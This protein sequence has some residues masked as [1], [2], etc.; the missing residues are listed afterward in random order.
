M[1]RDDMST[2]DGERKSGGGTKSLWAVTRCRDSKETPVLLPFIC[3]A[4]CTT[5]GF[6]SNALT[7]AVAGLT[8]ED[9]N[10]LNFVTAVVLVLFARVCPTQDAAG[11]CCCAPSERRSS[12]FLGVFGGS[13]PS[14]SPFAAH[15]DSF[16]PL[17]AFTDVLLQAYCWSLF[18]IISLSGPPPWATVGGGGGGGGDKELLLF[19]SWSAAAMYGE[20]VDDVT[21]QF[22]LETRS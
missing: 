3:N 2:E 8:S 5:T 10:A 16:F 6:F 22:S 18:V 19:S 21:L 14:H 20:K 7:S 12:L 4:A 1:L 11:C 13:S 17:T 15:G 9:S